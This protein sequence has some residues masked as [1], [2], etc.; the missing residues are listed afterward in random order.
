MF[1]LRYHVASLTA[2]FVA[3][4]LGILVGVGISGRGLVDDVERENLND[5]I[6]EVRQQRDEARA[7]VDALAQQQRAGEEL[8][9]VT[10][11][12]VMAGRLRGKRVALVQVGSVDA[13]LTTAVREAIRDAGG[14]LT[15]SVVLHVPLD[16]E[17]AVE[18]LRAALQSPPPPGE[19][20][21]EQIGTLLARDLVRGASGILPALAPVLVDEQSGA[22]TRPVDGVV[23]V[24]AAP[25]MWETGRFVKALYRGLAGQGVPAV[26]AELRTSEPS[27]VERFADQ[28]LATVD[29]VDG[30]AGKLAL[31]ALLAGAPAGHYGVKE[32]AQAVLPPIEPV[33]TEPGG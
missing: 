5:Q 2:V 11:P 6:A 19:V 17:R 9:R 24:R 7:L 25:Q 16:L 29:S 12:L 4:I 15:R 20:T 13:T 23:V 28:G 1:D 10:Y 32:T 22:M 8:A 31:A 26:G 18:A 33:V 3:L 14:Q 30:A 27:A 21:P